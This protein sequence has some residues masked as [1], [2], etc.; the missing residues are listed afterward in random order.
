MSQED[1]KYSNKFDSSFMEKAIRQAKIACE[2]GEVPVGAVIV[3]D[4]TLLAESHN[5]T[6]SMKDPTAHAEVLAIRKASLMLGDWRLV[7]CTLYTTLEPCAMCAGALVLAR[8]ER[9]VFGAMDPRSGMVGSLENLVSDVRLN[10]RMTVSSGVLAE[11]SGT[12]LRDY[13]KVRRS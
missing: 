4:G 7:G 2:L 13:F 1:R 11:E 3:K 5:L 9:L 8:I 6:G 12:L 10:H